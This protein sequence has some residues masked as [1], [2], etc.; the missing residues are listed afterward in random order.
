MS[1]AN[2]ILLDLG[3]QAT[4]S[5]L[6]RFFHSKLIHQ[7]NVKVRETALSTTRIYKHGDPESHHCNRRRKSTRPRTALVESRTYD[8]LEPRHW[9]C[10]LPTHP[11]DR[12]ECVAPQALRDNTFWTRSRSGI[13]PRHSQRH[14][15]Q[16]GHF[17]PQQCQRL[18]EGGHTIWK[19]GCVDQQCWDQRRQRIQ[20]GK[21]EKDHGSQLYGHAGCKC[22]WKL[23]A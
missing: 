14:I 12:A 22:H 11:H 6:F 20:C 16:I 15:P 5:A 13:K 10:H 3:T 4:Q 18:C 2:Q 7:P 8:V 23:L 21:C 19:R 1:S 9:P 17:R